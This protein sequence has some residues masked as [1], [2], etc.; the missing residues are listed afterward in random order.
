MNHSHVK[1]L[2]IGGGLAGASA[3]QAIRRHD[4]A[5]RLLMIGQ[6][7]FRPYHR[8]P[9]SKEYLR[10]EKPQAEIFTNEPAWFDDNHVEFQSGRR[11][12]SLDT[13]RAAATLDDGHEISFDNALI[14]TGGSAAPL[15][16]PGAKFP[17]VF[18]V[19]RLQDS[20]HLRNAVEKA[21]KEGRP[22]DRGRGRAVIIGG[23]FLGVELAASLT[24]MGLNATLVCGS[25]W[26]W[27]KIAGET[28]GRYLTK[29]LEKHGV[30][31]VAQKRPVR[32]DG[33]GRVQ[34]VILPDY[35]PLECDLVVPSVGMIPHKD[36]A[37][38]TP[39][40]SEKAIVV[41]EYARTNIRNI[42]AAGDCCAIFDPLFG[43]H[44]T[45]DH[46]DNAVQSGEL[47]G[48][49]MAG[50]EK[51]YDAV[52]NFFS[53]VFNL[54]LNGWGEARQ[55]RRRI[56]RGTPVSDHPDFAEIGIDDAGR[57][58]QVLC[59]NH[60]NEDDALRRLVAT[61]A[62]VQGREEALADAAKPL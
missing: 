29:F 3:A 42:Y 53:D 33:D 58:A 34:R 22:H 2:I 36:L 1:Y 50:V 31:V 12:V 14:A 55:V 59:L 46:W 38:G 5:G 20:D 8:P 10:G 61:R 54:T 51:K 56:L 49:N 19:R 48:T 17:N 28:T 39:I 47:A 60:T 15:D 35:E 9:L 30:R 44:R 27:S 16:I 37:R 62:D 57:V 43:K 41:D 6:E 45:L 26:P 13:A 21:K 25:P 18:Y 7:V 32:F 23:G 4:T 52:N 11:V 24:Q 40:L